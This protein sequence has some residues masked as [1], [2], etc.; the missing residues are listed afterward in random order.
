M[1]CKQNLMKKRHKDENTYVLPPLVSHYEERTSPFSYQYEEANEISR[2]V[3][4]HRPVEF[5]SC[6]DW[7]NHTY[8]THRTIEFLI[9]SFFNRHL[10]RRLHVHRGFLLFSLDFF[11]VY[12][13]QSICVRYSWWNCHFHRRFFVLLSG[14]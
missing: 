10:W 12:W 14:S 4:I 2:C 6:C 11:S 1:Q 9:G 3:S 8:R 13:I 5:S 7:P